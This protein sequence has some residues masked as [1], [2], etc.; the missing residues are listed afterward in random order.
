MSLMDTYN[1]VAFI[2][3]TYKCTLRCHM[4]W[5]HGDH[6]TVKSDDYKNEINLIDIKKI[7]DDLLMYTKIRKVAIS[8]AEPLMRK[9]ICEVLSLIKSYNFNVVLLTNATL[10]NEDLAKNI[11]STNID[12]IRIS[13]DGISDKHNAIRNNTMAYQNALVGIKNLRKFTENF[14]Y[15]KIVLNHVITDDNIM[16]FNHLLELGSEFSCYVS[17]QHLMWMSKESIQSNIQILKDSLGITDL[18]ACG[19]EN[20]YYFLNYQKLCS[21]LQKTKE[22][23]K[24]FNVNLTIGQFDN[25]DS[26][27]KWYSEQSSFPTKCTFTNNSLRFSADGSLKPCQY[28]NYSFGTI[29]NENLLEILTGEKKKTFDHFLVNHK[30]IPICQRCCKNELIGEINIK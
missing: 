9:D 29:K 7:L 23:A 6:G 8:G 27:R 20:S 10:I 11:I 19:F 15:P 24:N 17:F 16:N 30:N 4:C 25:Q 13:I 5:Y 18:T 3:L 22:K 28:I 14:N 21:A 2:E 1:Q 12:Q 26:I